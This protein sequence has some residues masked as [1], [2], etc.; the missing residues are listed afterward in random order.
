MN[1]T[2][3]YD[4][5]KT[6]GVSPED[7]PLEKY[8]DQSSEDL[9][10][11]I[12]AIERRLDNLHIDAALLVEVLPLTPGKKFWT[13]QEINWDDPILQETDI[14][15]TCKE[16]EHKKFLLENVVK[17][18][19]A[20]EDDNVDRILAQDKAY[21]WGKNYTDDQLKTFFKQH[22]MSTG[23]FDLTWALVENP[24]FLDGV[25]L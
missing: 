11:S 16:L 6:Y 23:F 5:F 19:K 22:H 18:R 12:R 20:I 3:P 17:L 24:H 10:S 14:F 2:L 13:L 15:E 8:T 9:R 21:T 7:Y 25:V 1:Y 4:K